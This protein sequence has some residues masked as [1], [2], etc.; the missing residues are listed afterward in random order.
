MKIV[1]LGTQGAVPSLD[2]NLPATAV[3][4]DDGSLIIFDAGEDVQRQVI[5]AN[6]KFNAKTTILISHM[7]ADHVI[8]LPGLLFSFYLNNRTKDLTIIGPEGL[9][10]YLYF[11]KMFVGLKTKTYPLKIIEIPIGKDW[12]DRAFSEPGIGN[13]VYVYENGIEEPF[14]KKKVEISNNTV[15][16]AKKYAI[17]AYYMQHSVPTFGFKL[18]EKPRPGRFHPERA[19]E[20]GIPQGYLWGKMQ[21]GENI[22]LEDGTEIEPIKEKV[23]D[24][25]R[26]GVKIF[27]TADTTY[28][29]NLEDITKDSDY[30]ICETTYAEDHRE[31]AEEK[32]HMTAKMAGKLARKAGAKNLLLTHFSLR[33]DDRSVFQNEA[34][35]EFDHVICGED[36]LE[37]QV[38]RPE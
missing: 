28:F 24:P 12:E 3:K 22:T 17:E 9:A 20:L 4:M 25:K 15:F 19:K 1:F 27:Y 37:V 34:Q 7:H 33:Y 38:E 8:G 10:G 18:Q 30:L 31:L 6:L 32:G 14:E 36:L 2:S 5:A 16:E 23:V 35:E 13:S 29:K 26:R 11:H 21:R